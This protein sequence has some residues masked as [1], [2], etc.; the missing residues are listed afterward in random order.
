MVKYRNNEFKKEENEMIK[1]DLPLPV[2]FFPSIDL[3][4]SILFC[5]NNRAKR[6]RVVRRRHGA[7]F[8]EGR[9]FNPRIHHAFPHEVFGRASQGFRTDLK[10]VFRDGGLVGKQLSIGVEQ[11]KHVVVNIIH[12][13]LVHNVIGSKLTNGLS[14]VYMIVSP[15]D[16]MFNRSAFVVILNRPVVFQRH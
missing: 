4:N 12:L 8:G 10:G 15:V 1:L 7:W 9:G 13:D 14:L 2:V 6:S 5:A 11:M 16:R 3:L